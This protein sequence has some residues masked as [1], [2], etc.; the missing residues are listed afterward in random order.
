MA[1]RLTATKSV[2][3]AAERPGLL[4]HWLA[5]EKLR[6]GPDV[7]DVA[8]V[9]PAV[10]VRFDRFAQHPSSDSRGHLRHAVLADA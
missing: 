5:D 4:Q 3:P 7:A 1:R 2:V 6:L 9:V 10:S 8:R